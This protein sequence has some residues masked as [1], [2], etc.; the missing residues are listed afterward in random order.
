MNSNRQS[1]FY[2][3]WVVFA[4]AVGLFWGPPVTVFTFSV[5]LKPLM[6]DFHASRVA[7][8]LGYTLHALSAAAGASVAGWLIDRYRT[9][10]VILLATVLFGVTLL[11]AKA[12]HHTP[13]VL[14]VLRRTGRIGRWRGTNSLL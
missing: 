9:R 3:W 10:R 11:C 4:A 7:I 6:Q 2:G 5:F 12:L 1:V 14:P 13:A 8:S